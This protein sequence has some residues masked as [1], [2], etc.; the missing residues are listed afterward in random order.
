MCFFINEFFKYKI[1]LYPPPP[2]PPLNKL[3]THLRK[4]C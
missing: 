1:H 3:T 2:L 4:S